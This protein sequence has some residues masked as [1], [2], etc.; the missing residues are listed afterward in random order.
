MGRKDETNP[1]QYLSLYST[2]TAYLAGGTILGVFSGRYIDNMLS[3]RPIFMIFG[4]FGGLT[5]GI[6]GT[7][8]VVNKYMD[9]GETKDD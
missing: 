6:Y 9:M 4:L 8:Q 7:W 3:T 1:I 2:I 5:V